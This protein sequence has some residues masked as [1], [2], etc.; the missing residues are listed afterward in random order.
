MTSTHR[1]ADVVALRSRRSLL[2]GWRAAVA[3]LSFCAVFA[4][5]RNLGPAGALP[6]ATQYLDN[7]WQSLSAFSLALLAISI[8]AALVPQRRFVRSAALTIAVTLGVAAGY[9][10][11]IG[12]SG[13]FVLWSAAPLGLTAVAPFIGIGLI[14]VALFLVA[15]RHDDAVWALRTAA[16]RNAELERAMTEARLA[17]LHAQVEPHFLFNTLAHLRR[18]YAT[19]P[20][21]G[22]EMLRN[23][24]R[25][26]GEAHAALGCESLPLA[27]DATLAE[28]YLELQRVR[29]GTRLSFSIQLPPATRSA[30]VPPMMLTTLVENCVEHALSPLPRGGTIHVSAAVRGASTSIDVA[31]NGR[32]FTTSAGSGVGL[33]NLRARLEML[34]GEAAALELRQNATGGVTATVVVPSEQAGTS[35]AAS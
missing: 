34:H 2:P 30:R 1:I 6:S 29:M 18:L 27:E 19:Q 17:V 14:G 8:T 13:V 4:L 16:E 24:M 12:S 15:E 23:L 5:T 22:R 11:A 21:A 26:I 20:T 9:A 7:L 33:A 3:L 35:H 31:D 10:L 32:G 25:Y 28:A